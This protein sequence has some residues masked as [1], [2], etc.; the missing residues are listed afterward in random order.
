[1]SDSY[2]E[3]KRQFIKIVSKFVKR[4]EISSILRLSCRHSNYI[5]ANL[6]SNRYL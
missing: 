4:E 5:S 3:I 2:Q 6:S 1:M